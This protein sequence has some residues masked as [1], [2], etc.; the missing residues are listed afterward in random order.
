MSL[1]YREGIQI[2]LVKYIPGWKYLFNGN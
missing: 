1:Q 2:P